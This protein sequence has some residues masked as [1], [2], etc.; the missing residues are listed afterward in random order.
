MRGR[1]RR[2]AI[3]LRIPT[4]PGRSTSGFDRPGRRWLLAPSTKRRAV[5]GESHGV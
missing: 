3:D 5:L 2:V 1:G 4:M